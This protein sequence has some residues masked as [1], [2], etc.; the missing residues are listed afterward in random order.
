MN[1][2]SI[3]IFS[4]LSKPMKLLYIFPSKQSKK[5]PLQSWIQIKV[6]YISNS[7]CTSV[8]ILLCVGVSCKYFH[9]QV[10]ARNHWSG[11]KLT[12]RGLRSCQNQ[13]KNKKWMDVFDLDGVKGL[14][15]VRVNSI[16][17]GFC[18]WFYYDEMVP[19]FATWVK[20]ISKLK[21]FPTGPFRTTKK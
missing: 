6:V 21:W 15:S 19:F 5:I 18:D 11:L 7:I 4:F 12:P 17:R 3:S 16:W 9:V 10:I 13:N 1:T 14:Q 2:I 20:N 8:E